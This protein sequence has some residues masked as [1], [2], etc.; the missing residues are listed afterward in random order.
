MLYTHHVRIHIVNMIKKDKTNGD[1]YLTTPVYMLRRPFNVLF[2]V[3]VLLSPAHARP[4]YTDLSN[5]TFPLVLCGSLHDAVLA[6][7]ESEVLEH[8]KLTGWN[9]TA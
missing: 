3:C 2:L 1:L 8:V 4:M 7:K 6:L 5:S 9:L